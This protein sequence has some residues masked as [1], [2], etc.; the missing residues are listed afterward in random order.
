MLLF[1]KRAAAAGMTCAD[2]Y[3]TINKS[4]KEGKMRQKLKML[5][6]LSLSVFLINGSISP[7]S[8]QEEKVRAKIG[9][10]IKSGD[11]TKSAKSQDDLNVNDLIRIYVHPEETSY[12]YVIHTDLKEAALLNMVQQKSRSSTLVMPS[13]QEFYQVDGTSPEETFTIIISPKDLT[14]VTEVLKNGTAPYKR[15]IGV[16]ESL[17]AKSKI[18]L[19]QKVE[20]PFAIAGNVRGGANNDI[21]PFVNNL[22]IFSGKSLLVKKYEFRV[23]K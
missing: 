19:S 15:W 16:E 2:N 12:V 7:V 8:A 10:Q 17:I 5:F 20:K 18:D 21:D 22:Q 9:I 6:L 3:E 11:Q 13:L 1:K 4:L 14:E 23:K